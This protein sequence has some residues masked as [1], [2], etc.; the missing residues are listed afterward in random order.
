MFA[1][2]GRFVVRHPWWVIV[3]WLVAGGLVIALAPKLTATTDEASFLPK[4]YES[5]RAIAVQQAAFPQATTPDALIVVEREDGAPMTDAD[6]T[7]VAGFATNITNQHI[8]H[9]VAIVPV[10]P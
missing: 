6:S 7:T 9:V 4:D 10:P 2:I 1:A 5:I 3:A 8:P